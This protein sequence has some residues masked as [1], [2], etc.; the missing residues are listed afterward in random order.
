[1]RADPFLCF[2][3]AVTCAVGA[4]VVA[5]CDTWRSSATKFDFISLETI[6]SGWNHCLFSPADVRIGTQSGQNGYTQYSASLCFLIGLSRTCRSCRNHSTLYFEA[7]NKLHTSLPAGCYSR[8]NMPGL[9]GEWRETAHFSPQMFQM[10]LP[11]T[12]LQ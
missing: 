6:G 12:Q 5:G 3:Q 1:M 11:Q 2:F 8:C 7:C 10:L 4:E 9:F